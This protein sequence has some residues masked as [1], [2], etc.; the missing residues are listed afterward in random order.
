MKKGFD[1]LKRLVPQSE[2][3]GNRVSRSGRQ[4]SVRFYRLVFGLFVAMLMVV[5]VSFLQLSILNE[6]VKFI[7]ALQNKVKGGWRDFRKIP[8]I[9][10]IL[11]VKAIFA[12]MK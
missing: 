2:N 11:Q 6:T 8:T 3:V 5:P 4:S 12:V 10:N 9:R 1:H 7:G